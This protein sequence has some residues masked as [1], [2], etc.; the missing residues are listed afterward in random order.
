MGLFGVL[1]TSPQAK[2]QNYGPPAGAILNLAGDP[3][4]STWTEYTVSFTATLTSTTITFLFRNDP[5]YT[6]ATDL[7]VVNDTTP[8]GNEFVYGAFQGGTVGSNP[9]GWTYD[10]DYTAPTSLTYNGVVQSTGT[11]GACTSTP[12]TLPGG[13][14]GNFWCDGTVQGY[15]AIDQVVSTVVGD[16]YTISFYQASE[17]STG[18]YPAPPNYQ[19]TSTN[20]DT[21]NDDGNGIDTLVYAGSSIPASVPEPGSLLLFFTCLVMAIP[22]IRRKFRA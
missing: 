7:S 11:P 18:S 8:A 19:A 13:G 6:A 14:A 9:V 21:T 12:N 3:I 15:D 16:E 1:L 5:G 2:A 17:D 4:T 22:M 10:P 20:G